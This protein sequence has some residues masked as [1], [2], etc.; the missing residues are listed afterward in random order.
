MLFPSL[1]AANLLLDLLFLT[2]TLS[3]PL[4]TPR[5]PYEP[6]V[7]FSGRYR[8][9]GYETTYQ[10]YGM[11]MSDDGF[12]NGMSPCEVGTDCTDCGV[13]V[14]QKSRSSCA[15]RFFFLSHW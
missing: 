4:L 13:Q 10:Y 2:P 7:H 5:L 11:T 15:P 8:Y 12:F 9:A 6:G 1:Y 3:K 14:S